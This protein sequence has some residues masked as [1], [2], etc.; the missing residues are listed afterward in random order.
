MTGKKGEERGKERREKRERKRKEILW[1][2][3]SSCL[4]FHFY[5]LLPFI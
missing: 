3:P 4:F 1:K 2:G 5:A